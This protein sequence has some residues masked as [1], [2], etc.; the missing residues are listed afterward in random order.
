MKNLHYPIQQSEIKTRPLSKKFNKHPPKSRA[1]EM[2][3]KSVAENA[4]VADEND[5]IDSQIDEQQ[6]EKRKKRRMRKKK[7]IGGSR[8]VAS[9]GHQIYQMGRD[10]YEKEFTI[11]RKALNL[12]DQMGHQVVE[13]IL[14]AAVH[15]L[16]TNSSSK[17]P[18]LTKTRA[19]LAMKA[20]LPRAIYDACLMEGELCIG[21]LDKADRARA[22]AI[23]AGEDTGNAE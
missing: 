13:D 7:F 12:M 11:G 5:H 3:K 22:R 19:R 18:K 20:V 2:G 10:K 21:R 17:T 23:A 9:T 15:L 14:E 4:A 8:W 16:R 6:Q 1:K